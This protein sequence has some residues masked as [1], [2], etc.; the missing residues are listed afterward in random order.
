MAEARK[1]GSFNERVAMAHERKEWVEE[2][3]RIER[4]ECEAQ[5]SVA[6]KRNKNKVKSL[7]AIALAL[8][9]TM[10]HQYSM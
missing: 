4:M 5:N 6:H 3:R 2:N 1:R 9:A 10:P 8:T 7:L